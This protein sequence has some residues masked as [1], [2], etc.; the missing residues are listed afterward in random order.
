MSLGFAV[1]TGGRNVF[2]KEETLDADRL[3]REA[4]AF[5]GDPDSALDA[6]YAALAESYS[7]AEQR[8]ERAAALQRYGRLRGAGDRNF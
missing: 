2:R 3:R 8:D 7:E 5:A 4:L 6:G 1:V